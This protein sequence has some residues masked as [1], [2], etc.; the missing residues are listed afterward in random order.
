FGVDWG[1]VNDYTV[2]AVIDA[3]LQSLV[4]IERF[5]QIDYALQRGRLTAL[6]ARFHPTVI[7][8]EVNAMGQP[9]VEQLQRDGLP[10]RAFTTTLASKMEIVEALALGL[11]QDRIKLIP[12]EI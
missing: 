9:I 8:A 12:D 10:V 11:E 5:N 1:K 3:T 7:M 6:H 2:I 4:H